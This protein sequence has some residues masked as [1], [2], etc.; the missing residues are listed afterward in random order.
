MSVKTS[1]F[2]ELLDTLELLG[3][4]GDKIGK[5][6]IKSGAKA[7]LPY[8]KKYAPQ[9]SGDSAKKLRVTSTK[10][11]KGNWWAQMGID[12][13]NWSACKSLWYQHWGFTHW[14]SGEKV[15][16]NVGWLDKAYKKAE[17]TIEEAMMNELDK[18]I[19]GILK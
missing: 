8:L 13:K 17:S 7:G 18:E 15:A 9:D 16:K 10:K 14:K 6:V 3:K 2:D 5:D 1:G 4:V 11:I 12:D 19:G